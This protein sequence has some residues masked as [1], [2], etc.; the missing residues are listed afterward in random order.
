[1]IYILFLLNRLFSGLRNGFGL[2]SSDI[3]KNSTRKYMRWMTILGI[4]TS[5]L[6]LPFT[7]AKDHAY[8]I[9]KVINENTLYSIGS[10]FIGLLLWIPFLIEKSLL[11]EAKNKLLKNINLLTFVELFIFVVAI[12]FLG[13]R[14]LTVLLLVFPA[15][16]LQSIGINLSLGNKWNFDT[17]LNSTEKINDYNF[18]GLKIPKLTFKVKLIFAIVSIFLYIVLSKFNLIFI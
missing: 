12:L 9:L 1:M 17:T 2:R 4:I 3:T 16:I 7:S 14:V 8:F 6:V 18:F 10:V 13:T 11:G 15:I 5:S